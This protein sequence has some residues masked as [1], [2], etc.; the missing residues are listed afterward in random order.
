M[1][2]DTPHKMQ[3][4]CVWVEGQLGRE[5]RALEPLAPGMGARRYWRARLVDG[6][7]RVLMHAV[8]EDPLILPP[9][10][11]RASAELPFV[12]LTRL[13]A[14]HGLPVPE[15]Y[16][17]EPAE[18]W[19]LLEDLGDVHLADLAPAERAPHYE[20]AIDLLAAT[21]R[22]P[23]GEGLPFDRSFDAEWIGFE[24]RHFREHGVPPARARALE[25]LL[26]ALA[27]R[28][29]ALP[30]AL[31]LRDYQSS[32]LMLDASGRLRI[33]D[34]QDALLAPP[35]LD[36]AALLWDSY[37]ALEH[38]QRELL[39]SRW[40]AQS[41]RA[42]DRDRLALLVVQRKLKDFARYRFMATTKGDPRFLRYLEPARAAVLEGLA[43]LPHDLAA[44]ARELLPL[45][46]AEAA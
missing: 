34:Y 20:R 44:L 8:P 7:T 17:V 21:H 15:L 11:R 40:T 9:Q 39:L 33:L 41:G 30:H 4:A 2:A 22:I 29:A 42:L 46:R 37:V 35:E 12:T 24:L 45:V 38:G 25:P 18:R 19:L 23:P 31:C 1:R 16:A 3:R 36:L 27:A 5:L 26:D 13:L 6:A 43:A 28:I 32:N 10:L 14:R